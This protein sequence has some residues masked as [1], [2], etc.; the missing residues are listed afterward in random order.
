MLIP[1]GPVSYTLRLHSGPVLIQEEPCLGGCDA[2]NMLILVSDIAPPE[3]R[4]MVFWHEF[5]HAWELELDPHELG[6]FGGESLAN[7]VALGMAR[8]SAMTLARVRLYLETGLESDDFAMPR[9]PMFIPVC[10]VSWDRA[11]A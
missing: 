6:T 10:R 11:R 2:D 5:A 4:M 7:L 3:R 9:C 8:M 1:V